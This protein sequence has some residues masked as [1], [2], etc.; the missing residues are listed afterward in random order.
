LQLPDKYK[1]NFIDIGTNGQSWA[2]NLGSPGQKILLLKNNYIKK[3][4]HQ[5]NITSKWSNITSGQPWAKNTVL[6]LKNNYINK[7]LHQKNITSNITSGQPWTK[8]TVLHLK[9][10]YIKKILHQKNITSNITSG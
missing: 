8:N 5:K 7:I 2:L 9:N 4:L 1:E 6:H 10:N 3:I